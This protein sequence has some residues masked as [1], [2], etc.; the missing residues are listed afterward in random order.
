LTKFNGLL[1]GDAKQPLLIEAYLAS[2]KCLKSWDNATSI[3]WNM[4][5]L[6][7][8]VLICKSNSFIL[9]K[10]KVKNNILMFY[11]SKM[12]YNELSRETT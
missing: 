9:V 2:W 4:M 8:V 6:L 10:K 3:I 5:F 11:F 12:F 1:V 7:H